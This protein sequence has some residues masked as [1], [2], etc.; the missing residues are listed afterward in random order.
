MV[1]FILFDPGYF[2]IPV[3]VLELCSRT[4]LSYLGMVQSLRS[5]FESVRWH[6]SS[7][8]VGGKFCPTA[9]I[10]SFWAVSLFPVNWEDVALLVGTGTVSRQARAWGCPCSSASAGFLIHSCQMVLWEWSSLPRDSAVWILATLASQLGAL[11][12]ITQHSPVSALVCPPW[13]LA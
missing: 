7:I 3:N 11:V 2:Y 12:C 1:N 4:H 5:C 9:D 13:A 10:K 6:Q 8:L